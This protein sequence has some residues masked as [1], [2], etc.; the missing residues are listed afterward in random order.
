MKA[1]EAIDRE[2]WRELETGFAASEEGSSLVR[3]E[4]IAE[5]HEEKGMRLQD[6]LA[7]S[8]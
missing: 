5:E 7:T 3:A 8:L 6:H 4:R 1:F 2:D